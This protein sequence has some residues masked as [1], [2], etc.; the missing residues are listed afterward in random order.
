MILLQSPVKVD[1]AFVSG[2]LLELVNSTIG[3]IS[4]VMSLRGL[5]L[6]RFTAK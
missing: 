1:V 2:F 6:G 5:P 4:L 3:K